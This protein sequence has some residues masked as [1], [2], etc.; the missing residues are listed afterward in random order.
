MLGAATG[1]DYL[2]D[3]LAEEITAALSRLKWLFVVSRHAALRYR[4]QPVEPARIGP[5]WGFVTSS[6]AACA[7]MGQSCA[8]W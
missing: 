2:A 5:N 3:G 7:R 4:G 6:A 1:E 8:S